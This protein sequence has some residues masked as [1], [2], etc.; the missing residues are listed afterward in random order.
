M[1]GGGGRRA[2]GRESNVVADN[3]APTWALVIVIL[4]WA[5][6]QYGLAVWT[7][8]DLARRD[9]VAGGSKTAW[10]LGLLALPVIGPLAYVAAHPV[11]TPGWLVR[12]PERANRT[13]VWLAQGIA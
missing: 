8:R 2:R 10:T 11:P 3:G 7:L 1:E 13:R 12:L 6:A 9:D 5:A 4:F